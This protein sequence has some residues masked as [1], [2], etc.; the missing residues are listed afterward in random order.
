VEFFDLWTLAWFDL[1]M[2][3]LFGKRFFRNKAVLGL[4]LGSF[5]SA[6]ALAAMTYVSMSGVS[7]KDETDLTKPIA[8]G[9]FAGTCTGD[10][11]VPCDSC[12]GAEIDLGGGVKTKLWPCNKNNAYTN[13]KFTITATFTSTG[14][15]TSNASLKNGDTE[16]SGVTFSIDGNSL[17][18]QVPWGTLCT[19]LTSTSGTCTVDKTL[20]LSLTPSGGT[21]ESL[22]FRIVAR[23]VQV[24][25]TAGPE[26]FYVDCNTTPAAANYGFC[27]FEAYPGDA[28]IYADNLV[29]SPGYPAST[30]GGIEYTNVVF[31]FKEYDGVSDLSTVEAISNAGDFF[32]V[33]VNKSAS[34]P[35]ADNRIEGLTN[36]VRY[37]MMMANQDATGIISFFTPPPASGG[38]TVAELCTTPTEVIGLLDD[39]HCFIATAA[40][41]S[42]MAPE[43]QSFRDFRNRYLLTNTWGRAFVKFYYKHSPYYANLIA[44]S[45]VAKA[46]VRGALWPLLL[47]ARLSV[48]WGLLVTA[49]VFTAVAGAV[50]VIWR[51]RFRGGV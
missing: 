30:V 23:E 15:T 48:A 42:D 47:F 28:K 36:G 25:S 10:G 11:L 16:I 41:G 45:E 2:R 29:V 46:L 6:P 49:L 32:T 5:L 22:S 43:V 33:G 34:P 4:V 14:V 40:F 50:G 18:A 31:F 20:T 38:S 35:V 1:N 27:H 13:L 44:E 3:V 8:Y 17:S 21:A 19:S 12:T 7:N 24:G 37:C 26:W 9:G 39:K 51:R